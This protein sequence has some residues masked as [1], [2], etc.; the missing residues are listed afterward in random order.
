MFLTNRTY[1][2]DDEHYICTGAILGY[3][4]VLTSYQCIFPLLMMGNYTTVFTGSSKS[5][6][7]RTNAINNYRLPVNLTPYL[8]IGV[9]ITLLELDGFVPFDNISNLIKISSK[10]DFE[11]NINLTIVGYSW[12]RDVNDTS[13]FHDARHSSISYL[14]QGNC[15]NKENEYLMCVGGDVDN[16]DGGANY[17]ANDASLILTEIDGDFV[18]SGIVA[19]VVNGQLQ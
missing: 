6:S 9:D 18:L 7:G 3:R 5:L 2:P 4:W 14:S 16:D 10:T 19:L 1:V 8:P 11:E 17:Q 13:T 12:Y 15:E